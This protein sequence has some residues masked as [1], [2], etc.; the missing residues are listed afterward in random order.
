MKELEKLCGVERIKVNDELGVLYTDLSGNLLRYGS[1][2]KVIAQDVFDFCFGS[3][4]IL[5]TQKELGDL[6]V[7][8]E[9]S[10][11]VLRGFYYLSFFEVFPQ[12]YAVVKNE[13]PNDLS[14][15]VVLIDQS[16]EEQQIFKSYR[17]SIEGCFA[18]FS[19]GRIVVFDEG[20]NVVWE[21]S[22]VEVDNSFSAKEK[23]MRTFYTANSQALLIPFASGKLLAL[24]IFTGALMW[25]NDHVGRFAVFQNRLYCIVDSFIKVF[26]I[27]SG[28][29]LKEVS[30]Q[31]LTDS[32][33]FIPTGRHKVYNDSIFV[34]STDKQGKVAVF[35]RHNLKFEEMIVLNKSIPMSNESLYW[36][37]DKLYI[38]DNEG[39]LHI[40]EKET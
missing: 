19:K 33:E 28:E 17:A 36:F 1:N 15:Q 14:N 7:L 37:K 25:K 34:M 38:L 30:L 2:R 16:F 32:F 18:T 11:K 26:E 24:D 29:F 39:T 6:F 9:E 35:N 12:Y 8:T 20:K 4:C 27:S 40:F 21:R 13:S 5:Y 10:I 31:S 23:P 3:N 22:L